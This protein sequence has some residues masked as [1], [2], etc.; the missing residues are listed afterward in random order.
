MH[1]RTYSYTLTVGP[2]NSEEVTVTAGIAK[3]KKDANNWVI[4]KQFSPLWNVP[5]AHVGALRLWHNEIEL[6]RH[7]VDPVHLVIIFILILILILLLSLCLLPG[8]R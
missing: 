8:S 7:A 2:P 5:E 1:D 6:V 4:T 3:S